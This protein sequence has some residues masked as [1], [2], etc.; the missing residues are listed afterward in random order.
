MRL[1]SNAVWHSLPG[2]V[3]AYQPI[4]APDPVAARQNV[5]V[6]MRRVGQYSAA[7]GVA[8][9]WS[10][11]TGWTFNGT[12]QFLRAGVIS[13]NEVSLLCRFSDGPSSS[14]TIVVA[15]GATWCIVAPHGGSTQYGNGVTY[16]HGG[17]ARVKAPPLVSG[18]LGLTPARCYRNGIDDGAVPDLQTLERMICIGAEGINATGS[19]VSRHFPGK[20]QA[21][22]VCVRTFSP[23]EFWLASRQM[24]YCNS[25]PDWNAWARRRMYFYAPAP[26]AGRVG[27]YGRRG[28]V[29]LPGG[30]SIGTV[31]DA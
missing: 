27:I 25:N 18:V 23:A 8:P 7:P 9:T 30:V 5:G 11:T 15:L 19:S 24:A 22:A 14:T 12:D 20:I 16:M 13:S 17:T 10:A 28:A 1:K 31:N 29:A 3:A 26:A 21:V 4:A 6:N 2:V